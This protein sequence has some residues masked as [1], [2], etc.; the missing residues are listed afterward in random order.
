MGPEPIS[1]PIKKKQAKQLM[2][3]EL[4]W[5]KPAHFPVE[6][7]NRKKSSLLSRFQILIHLSCWSY[8]EKHKG[9]LVML[10]AGFWGC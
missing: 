7:A 1:S 10:E 3:A 4:N 8:G 5:K 6:Q 9:V 2:S